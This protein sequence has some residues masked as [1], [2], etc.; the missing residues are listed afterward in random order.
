MNRQSLRILLVVASASF[1]AACAGPAPRAVAPVEVPPAGPDTRA[2][3]DAVRA[4][5]AA[6]DSIVVTPLLDPQAADLRHAA[7]RL[8]AEGLYAQAAEALDRAL[9]ISPQ[10]PALLQF[11]AE[12]ALLQSDLDRALAMA[13]R[14]YEIGPRLGPLCRRNWT[15][16]RVVREAQ[17]YAEHAEVARERFSRCTVEPPVRM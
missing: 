8:E 16:V 7:E 11:A 14:S 4:V 9:Q 12:L 10:D 6:E 17:G 15:T 13:G 3:V 5:D 2:L 1:L